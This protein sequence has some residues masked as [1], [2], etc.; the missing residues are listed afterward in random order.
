MSVAS[1]AKTLVDD[2][3][4]CCAALEAS[5]FVESLPSLNLSRSSSPMRL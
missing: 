5:I 2:E 3:T 1:R 4:V